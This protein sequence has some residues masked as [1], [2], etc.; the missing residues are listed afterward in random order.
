MRAK[1]V[2]IRFVATVVFVRFSQDALSGFIPS[3]FGV[4]LESGFKSR[5]TSFDFFG[6]TVMGC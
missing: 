4:L 6:I 3:E 2:V 5:V 1:T